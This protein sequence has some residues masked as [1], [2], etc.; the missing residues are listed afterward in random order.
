M[1]EKA[2]PGGKPQGQSIGVPILSVPLSLSLSLSLG[3]QL[4]VIV[5]VYF[6]LSVDRIHSFIRSPGGFSLLSGTYVREK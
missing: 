6:L 1:L 3:R 4:L 2:A 5:G